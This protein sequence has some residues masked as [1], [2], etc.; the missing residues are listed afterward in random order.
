MA[1]P[2]NECVLQ[3]CSCIFL[4]MMFLWSFEM[5]PIASRFLCIYP[6]ATNFGS[7]TYDRLF[8]KP[9]EVL[10]LLM[11]KVEVFSN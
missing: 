7:V 2:G 4:K 3:I 8:Y 1:S 11:N 10:F 5:P 9:I 6:F